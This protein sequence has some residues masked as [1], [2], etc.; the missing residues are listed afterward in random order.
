MIFLGPDLVV[1]DPWAAVAAEYSEHRPRPADFRLPRPYQAPA[2]SAEQPSD[3]PKG[4]AGLG[5]SAAASPAPPTSAAADHAQQQQ[6]QQP[7]AGDADAAG[8]PD[9]D[10]ARKRKKRARSQ[11]KP[12]ER[13]LEAAARHATQA[14][15]L[16]AAADA[17]AAWLRASGA[18]TVQETLRSVQGSQIAAAQQADGRQPGQQRPGEQPCDE[19]VPA[20]DF[21]AMH[22][23]RHAL[24]PKLV[25][26]ADMPGSGAGAAAAGEPAP[27]RR[28]D[29][30]QPPPPPPCNLFGRLV[31]SCSGGWDGGCE[32]LAYAGG[33][34]VLL[35]PRS[36]FLMSDARQLQPLVDDAAGGHGWQLAHAHPDGR[37]SSCCRGELRA[38]SS[39]L[40]DP[41]TR[42]PRHAPVLHAG[43]AG[44][45]HCIVLDPPWENASAKRSARYPTLP[46]R[47]LLALPLR[48][49]MAAE[50]CLVAMWVTNRERHRRFID[51]GALTCVGAWA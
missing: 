17:V 45:Y 13:E 37:A 32:R 48:A 20:P 1:L 50:G 10:K 18:A 26:A 51:Q 6:L 49:L 29:V 35:P 42:T 24:Q 28:Q 46:S 11:Y 3:S 34:P 14:P 47:N 2:K 39:A 25:F 41:A 31:D 40:H 38:L 30:Q 44:G 23:L 8:S 22:E 33:R 4:A 43:P 36:R 27:E 15:L 9:Q 7:Q 19:G 21:R 5:S 16:A 12:N